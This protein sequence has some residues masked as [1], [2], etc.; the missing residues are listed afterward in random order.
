MAALSQMRL[1]LYPEAIH[2]WKLC[3]EQALRTRDDSAEAYVYE[4]LSL[5]HFYLGQMQ[6][7]EYYN[8]RFRMGILEEDQ[9]QIRSIYASL[10]SFREKVN[11]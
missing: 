5:C 2:A 6:K 3:L 7:A 9:S 11:R 1:K 4:Q 10:R 8:T